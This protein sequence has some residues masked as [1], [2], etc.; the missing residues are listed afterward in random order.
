MCVCLCFSNPR[1][2]REAKG[3]RFERKL[4]DAGKPCSGKLSLFDF[5]ENKLPVQVEQLSN[6]NMQQVPVK[7][8]EFEHFQSKPIDHSQSN[9]GGR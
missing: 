8:Y 1:E 2:Q 6:A 3:K 9:R 7:D 4:E 5:L